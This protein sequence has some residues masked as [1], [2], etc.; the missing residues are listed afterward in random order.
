MSSPNF[1]RHRVK[2]KNFSMSDTRYPDIPRYRAISRHHAR[3]VL[4]HRLT[5]SR[6]SRFL[7]FYRRPMRSPGKKWTAKKGG[8]EKRKT[9]RK[10]ERRGV[11]LKAG[12]RCFRSKR[13]NDDRRPCQDSRPKKKEIIDRGESLRVEKKISAFDLSLSPSLSQL[14]SSPLRFRTGTS[15]Y[16]PRKS[17]ASSIGWYSSWPLPL[18]RYPVGSSPPPAPHTVHAGT[19]EASQPASL[20]ASQPASHIHVYFYEIIVS[21]DN[22]PG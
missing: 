10:E 16:F 9:E 4:H 7:L 1:S 2:P 19:Q 20:P 11:P 8:Y 5:P 13:W 18:S 6:A 22:T 15:I 17:A 21:N 12:L 14:F 3:P